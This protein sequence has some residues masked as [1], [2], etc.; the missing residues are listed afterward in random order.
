MIGSIQTVP[1]NQSEFAINR[2]NVIGRFAG[3]GI[4]GAVVAV[5]LGSAFIAYIF[6]LLLTTVANAVFILSASPF[7]AALL[8]R[9]VLGER[10]SW[11]A[12]A[13]MTAALSGVALTRKP[14]IM[15]EFNGVGLIFLSPEG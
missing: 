8:S 4:W 7:L 15:L 1:V 12:W 2:R 13:C 9:V 3:I 6:S 11:L 14:Y 10:V 5:C